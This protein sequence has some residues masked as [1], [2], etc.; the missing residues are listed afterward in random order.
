M[1]CPCRKKSESATYAACCKPYHDGIAVAPSAEALMRSRY[2]AFVLQNAAYLK[3][4]WHAST[5]PERIDFTPG[6]EWLLLRV[7][8]T[9]S[10]G[11]RATV[12]FIA[13]SRVAGR[14]HEQHE[15]SRFVRIGGHWQ[16]VDA[17]PAPGASRFNPPASAAAGGPCPATAW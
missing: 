7:I 16:Y 6:Q 10:D 1:R 14:M 8:R 9:R 5:R 11:D 12:E 13:R 15:V 4:T 3:A 17:E 2:A